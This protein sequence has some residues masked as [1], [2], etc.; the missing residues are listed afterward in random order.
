MMECGDFLWELYI[1][2]KNYSCFESCDLWVKIPH[3]FVAGI[4]DH[5]NWFPLPCLMNFDIKHHYFA[6][7]CHRNPV[8]GLIFSFRL[9]FFHTLQ[10]PGRQG[11]TRYVKIYSSLGNHVPSPGTTQLAWL[12]VR[13]EGCTQSC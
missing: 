13:Y 1:R 5:V 11:V 10:L 7:F 8:L 4:F 12:S 9:L 2:T 6:M 3:R